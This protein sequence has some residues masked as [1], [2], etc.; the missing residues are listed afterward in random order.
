MT[1]ELKNCILLKCLRIYQWIF[2]LFGLNLPPFLLYRLE[3]DFKYYTA[4]IVYQVYCV[5]VLI[6]AIWTVIVHNYAVYGIANIHH[7]DG[8]TKN[9]AYIHNIALAS[10]QILLHLKTLYGNQ[11]LK[12]ILDTI[13]VVNEKIF[14][15]RS[16][17]C[18]RQKLC[19]EILKTF[20]FSFILLSITVWYLILNLLSNDISLRDR[21]FIAF[22]NV[23]LQMKFL[24]YG[25][26]MRMILDYM[27][28]T[29]NNLKNLKTKV[30]EQNLRQSKK[31]LFSYVD[32]LRNNQ[33]VLLD[34]C[35]LVYKFEQYFTWPIMTLFLYNGLVILNTCN[36]AYMRYLYE[37]DEVH[38]ICKYSNR[39][40]QKR[41]KI[42][43][44]I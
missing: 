24:E 7:L 27:N 13:K 44:Y 39:K 30:N 38:Q 16:M 5:T 34:I 15:L 20:G 17:V 40:G 32:D 33:A 25:V 10:I 8:I 3:K 42:T 11:D 31:L 21:S 12:L 2:T 22:I 9:M 43:C 18:V 6:I 19:F 26:Y 35:D 14:K 1:E 29:I 37:T 28:V 36:W 41:E 4:S 23:S